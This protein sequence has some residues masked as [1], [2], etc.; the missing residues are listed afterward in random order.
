MRSP[1]NRGG[2]RFY[3]IILALIGWKSTTTYFAIG[4]ALMLMG[5]GLHCW[6]K[7]CLERNKE[8]AMTGPYRFVRHP[9][10]LAN[11][12]IDSGIVVGS[13]CW[14]LGLVFPFW[15]IGVYLPVIRQE[16]AYL[17]EHFPETYRAYRSRVPALLPIRRPLPKQSGG[18]RR[19]I[20][21]IIREREVQRALRLLTYPLFFFLWHQFR[22]Y[23]AGYFKSHLATIISILI[24]MIALRG[25]AWQMKKQLKSERI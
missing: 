23:G 13:G 7:A 4:V 9:F 21:N 5:I 1:L 17:I 12:L 15:W 24:L 18:S 11:A 16:E 8:V 10:Y 22:T 20:A 19:Q 6:A 3:L 25:P 14:L 2:I